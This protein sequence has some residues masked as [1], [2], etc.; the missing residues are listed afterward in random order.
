MGRRYKDLVRSIIR[1]VAAMMGRILPL[2]MR[3]ALV[4]SRAGRAERGG[5]EFALGML[6]DLRQRD[7][8]AFHR[9]LWSNH[10][11]YAATYE[12]DQ[13]FGEE[14]LNPSRRI[15]VQN[16][17]GYLRARGVDPASNIHS[18]LDIGCSMGYLLR[19]IEVGLCPSAEV[20]HGL[21]I[22]EYAI[23][24]G[25]A[26]LSSMQSKVKLFVGDMAEAGR[27][28]GGRSY[29]LILCCGVLMYSDEETAYEVVR[30]MLSTAGC[31]VGIICLAD[32]TSRPLPYG[33]GSVGCSNRDSAVLSRAREQ[34]VPDLFP[35]PADGKSVARLSDGA[36]IHDVIGMIYRA[37]G[38]VVGSRRIETEISGSSPSFAIL[39]EPP[40]SRLNDAAPQS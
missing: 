40:N 32:P 15:L 13:R 5:L 28:A 18:V 35:Q 11:A 25:M 10:L 12:V 19:H 14:N 37:G 26:H 9:F 4:A 1:S 6:G 22:D 39:A 27:F 20:L 30:T 8:L 29:D 36:F 7:A 16:I 31:L 17:G 24:S 38:K 21:D 23:Q 3:Q 2:R 33:R 34:A